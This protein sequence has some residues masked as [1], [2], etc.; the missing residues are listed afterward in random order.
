V[1]EAS[2]KWRRRDIYEFEEGRGRKAKT[3]TIEIFSR[4][5]NQIKALKAL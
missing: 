1:V 5:Q 2:V 3:K 4:S